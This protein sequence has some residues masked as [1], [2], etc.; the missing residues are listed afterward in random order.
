MDLTVTVN[1][2]VAGFVAVATLL[3]SITI[4]WRHINKLKRSFDDK[5][6][7]AIKEVVT[8]SNNRQDERTA[9]MLENLKTLFTSEI[10]QIENKIMQYAESYNK[11]KQ[12]EQAMINLLKESLIEA[13]KNDI[14]TV[15]YKLR[16][17]G[18]ILDADKSYVDKI[19]PKYIAIG[20]NSDISAKYEEICR[21][22]ERRTQEKYDEAFEKK[23]TRKRATSKKVLEE[24]DENKN[25][26]EN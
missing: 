7:K 4:I 16:D 1:Q 13:Y 25:L 24:K 23:K 8:G 18:E 5:L 6:E 14:R 19:F 11:D 15:Y 26:K 12:E 20:G 17:T 22:Y 2:I 9:L 21:V 3:T 10:R